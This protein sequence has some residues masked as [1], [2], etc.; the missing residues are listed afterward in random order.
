MRWNIQ[1]RTF[2]SFRRY[3]VLVDEK[4]RVMLWVLYFQCDTTFHFSLYIYLFS[5]LFHC[6]TCLW[7]V[8]IIR[9]ETKIY[10]FSPF[11]FP[12]DS[13][14]EGGGT[15]GLSTYNG[16][17]RTLPEKIKRNTSLLYFVSLHEER[18]RTKTKADEY[19]EKFNVIRRQRLPEKLRRNG[20]KIKKMKLYIPSLLP[21]MR[22]AES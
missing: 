21:T 22:T 4:R 9:N 15:H 10:F 16:T 2:S 8:E 17:D 18:E 19:D 1:R 14:H 12:L 11:L 3:M 20:K 13:Q 6:F 7:L 5:V